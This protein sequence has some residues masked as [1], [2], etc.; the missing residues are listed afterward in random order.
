MPTIL[1]IFIRNGCLHLKKIDRFTL[2]DLTD[3]QVKQNSLFEKHCGPIDRQRTDGLTVLVMQSLFELLIANK[4]SVV[5][6]PKLTKV[7]QK[8]KQGN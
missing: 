8:V 5:K 7:G 1:L 2:L 3:T 4:N 6:N